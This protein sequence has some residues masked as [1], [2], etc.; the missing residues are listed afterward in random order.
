MGCFAIFNT[1]NGTQDLTHANEHSAT[2]PASRIFFTVETRYFIS[3]C[4]LYIIMDFILIFSCLYLI[5]SLC[6]LPCFFHF[7]PLLI[8]FHSQLTP[9]LFSSLWV[10]VWLGVYCVCEGEV[11]VCTHMCTCI[12]QHDFH[13][14]YLQEN[15]GL[16]TE[17]F[18]FTTLI[19]I[20]LQNTSLPPFT[21]RLYLSL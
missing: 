5:Y 20:S 10:F 7:P 6:P 12:C 16:F 13:Y 19:A 17:G 21:H 8:P 9:L 11:S 18:F 1:E 15:N 3:V 14:C 2:T 4:S